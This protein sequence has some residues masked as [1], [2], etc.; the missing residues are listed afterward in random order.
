MFIL[1]TACCDASA[2]ENIEVL[3]SFTVK[4]TYRQEHAAGINFVLFISCDCACACLRV[5]GLT[6][7]EGLVT[8][9]NVMGLPKHQLNSQRELTEL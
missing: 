4:T 8:S 3:I 9:P 5:H 2:S 7:R 6:N 1:G